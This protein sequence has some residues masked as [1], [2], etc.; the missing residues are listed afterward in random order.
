MKTIAT[1]LALLLAFFLAPNTHSQS[2]DTQSNATGLTTIVTGKTAGLVL[3]LQGDS[4]FLSTQ[5]GVRDAGWGAMAPAEGIDLGEVKLSGVIHS[6]VGQVADWSGNELSYSGNLKLRVS[7]LSP[8]MLMQAPSGALRLFSGN[9]NGSIVSGGLSNRTAAPAYP[10]YAAYSS[11]GQ[12]WVVPLSAQTTQLPS[13][14]GGWLLLWYGTNSYFADT[15][16]PGVS[17]SLDVGSGFSTIPQ[18]S[19]YQADVPMLLKFQGSPSSIG[20][21]PEGGVDVTF[22]GGYVVV[23]PLLG[24][25]HPSATTTETWSTALPADI[26][27]KIDFWNERLCSYPASVREEYSYNGNVNFTERVNFLPISSGTPFAALPPILSVSMSEGNSIGVSLSGSVVDANYPTPF[28]PLWGVDGTDSYT[29]SVPELDRYIQ[30]RRSAS[31]GQ[32]PAELTV[33]LEALVQN[34]IAAGHMK[35]WVFSNSFPI[36]DGH[37]DVYFDNPADVLSALADVADALSGETKR[38]LVDYMR[39]ERIQYPPETVYALPDT[40]TTRT[41][42]DPGTYAWWQTHRSDLFDN[43]VHVYNFY[44]LSRYYDLTG[45]TVPSPVLD[46][47]GNALAAELMERDWATFA[48]FQGFADAPLSVESANR[49]LTGTLGYARLVQS[50]GQDRTI[51]MSAF[52]K[53]VVQRVG[54][55]K[56]PRFLYSAGL[57]ELPSDP[58]WQ[59]HQTS[60][61]WAGYMANYSW[62]SPYDDPRQLDIFDQFGSLLHDHTGRFTDWG[63]DW[64]TRGSNAHLSAFYDL[65]TDALNILADYAR[66]DADVYPTKIAAFLPGWYSAY[67]EAAFG[68]E[69]DFIYPNDSFQIFMAKSL[70]SGESPE[71]LES[72]VD[73][74]WLDMGDLFYMGKL[75]E[76]VKRYRG[77][78]WSGGVPVGS[79]AIGMVTANI[80]E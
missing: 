26:R 29:W 25:D 42:F 16:S 21:S 33:E 31:N 7:R 44:G 18:S 10:K 50:A 20:Q 11:G 52:A 8:A 60:R 69:Q 48:P 2:A 65:G 13:L 3:R 80:V 59:A 53:A 75:A 43:R 77:D 4:R 73:V 71:T 55:A 78:T 45:D 68:S 70:V 17:Y 57:I 76:T 62:T 58:A 66:M 32:V 46:A 54:M 6:L 35:P 67:S 61:N 22:G 14:D 34:L 41:P 30:G 19:A 40:G 5:G 27:S 37:G 47:G 1:I 79:L 9:L 12:T 38:R 24:I 63:T 28:G 49:L 64:L 23:M 74:P 72:Y 36:G 51:S 15:K 56:F 39:S